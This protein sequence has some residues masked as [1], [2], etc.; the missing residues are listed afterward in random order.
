MIGKL[1]FKAQCSS[2]MRQHK[3]MAEFLALAKVK[4]LLLNNHC[5]FMHTH[6]ETSDENGFQVCLRLRNTE[7]KF[8]EKTK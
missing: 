5:I 6:T 2:Q 1:E 4:L 3:K 8:E 7:R